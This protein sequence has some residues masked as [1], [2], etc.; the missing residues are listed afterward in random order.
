VITH[1]TVGRPVMKSMNARSG[2]G[3][4]PQAHP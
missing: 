2:A 4:I 3:N 1:E